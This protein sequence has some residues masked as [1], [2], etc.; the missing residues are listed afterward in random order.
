MLEKELKKD[1]LFCQIMGRKEVDKLLCQDQD[2]TWMGQLLARPQLIGW[3][4][5]FATFLEG[6]ELSL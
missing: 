1:S 5:Q 3:L 2:S 4:Y 6:K